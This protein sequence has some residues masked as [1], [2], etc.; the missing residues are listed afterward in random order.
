MADDDAAGLLVGG[1]GRLGRAVA[2]ALDARG[3]AF[4]L[5]ARDAARAPRG[6]VSASLAT[7]D[8]ARPDS[9]RQALHGCRWL[10]IVPPDGP[11]MPA[12]LAGL[13][14]AAM[15]AGVRRIVKVSAMLARED[16]PESFGIEH[17]EADAHL[18]GSGADWTVLRPSFFMQSFAMFADPMR[19]LGRIPLPCGAG[20]VAF[21]DIADIA[22]AA[23]HCLDAPQTIRQAYTLTGPRAVGFD[24]AA[25]RIGAA[26]GM[27]L[28]YKPLPPLL[29]GW[30]LRLAAG[31]D[32]WTVTRLKQLCAA[33]R[34]GKEAQ[35]TGDLEQL[36]GRPGRDFADFAAADGAAILHQT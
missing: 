2:Q 3:Q 36:L 22:A 7:G 27:P 25:Q 12:L 28:A 34:Q 31:Q 13:V 24:E 23:V 14:D 26:A 11:Q 5:L 15:A 6:L 16:P 33:V 32:G 21:I 35:V 19:K 17:A 20:R 4:R 30:L 1:T 10:L 8:L 9:L 29:F 18:R